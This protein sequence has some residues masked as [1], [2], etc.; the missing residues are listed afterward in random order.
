MSGYEV[1]RAVAEATST[2]PGAICGG[3]QKAQAATAR[4]LCWYLM[5]TSLGLRQRD[6]ARWFDVERRAL[7]YGI[8][9]VEDRR[10]DAEFD[11]LVTKLEEKVRAES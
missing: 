10:D 5:H 9:R 11:A 6:I 3:S 2:P 7:Q 8:R 1:L 4:H